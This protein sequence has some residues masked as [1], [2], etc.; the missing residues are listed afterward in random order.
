M[1]LSENSWFAKRGCPKHQRMFSI[2]SDFYPL[3]G[4]ATPG[5]KLYPDGAPGWE[6]LSYHSESST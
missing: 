3:D 2:I 4:V 5:L 1:L 6:P